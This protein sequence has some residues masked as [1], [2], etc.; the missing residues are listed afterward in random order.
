M[1]RK[2]FVYLRYYK[3]I[4]AKRLY[5]K[6]SKCNIG[7]SNIKELIDLDMERYSPSLIRGGN[8][9]YLLSYLLLNNKVFRTQFYFR[10]EQN[11]RL[12]SSLAKAFSKVLLPPL[13]NVQIGIN[14]TGF[15]DGGLFVAHA[16]GCVVSIHEAGKNLTIYQGVTVGDSGERNKDGVKRP[17]FGDNVTIFANAVVA[18]GIVVGSNVV[19]GAGSV[20]TKDVPDNC[21]VAGNPARI[22]KKDGMKVNIPL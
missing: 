20:V 19:I 17:T 18:G 22:I 10:I 2:S 13:E 3:L 6:A 21:V 11:K 9:K 5:K 14:N 15:V 8:N 4:P 12:G 16:S 7:N 1:K